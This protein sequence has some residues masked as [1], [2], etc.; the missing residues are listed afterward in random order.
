M[1]VQKLWGKRIGYFVPTNLSTKTVTVAAGQTS[2][3]VAVPAGAVVLGA[4]P[5]GNQDQLIDNIS[6]SG[7]TLTVTLGAAATA[8]NTIK[9]TVLGQ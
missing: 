8:D 1:F 6:V 4:Y 9:V 5:G 7:T 3:T 2:G